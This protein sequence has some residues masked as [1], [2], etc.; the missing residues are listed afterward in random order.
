QDQNA[1]LSDSFTF[2]P[3]WTNEFRL[4][5]GRTAHYVP[6]F[7]SSRA[8]PEA[9]TQPQLN[10]ALI[11]GPGFPS[12]GQ[13]QIANNWLLQE[14]QTRV[15]GRHTLRYGTELAPQAAKQGANVQ[16]HGRYDYTTAVG[17]SALANFLDDY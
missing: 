8:I 6:A 17:Y 7:I 3:A 16:T 11:S 5:Y 9:F 1:L 12:D 14:T 4:S 13:Y 10:I 15:I 2:L